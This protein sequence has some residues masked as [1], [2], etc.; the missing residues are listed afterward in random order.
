M[1]FNDQVKQYLKYPVLGLD[2]TFAFGC[3]GCGKCNVDTS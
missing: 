3:D 2:D 1:N